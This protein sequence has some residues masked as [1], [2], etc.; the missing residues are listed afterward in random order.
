MRGSQFTPEDTDII[1]SKSAADYQQAS[2]GAEPVQMLGHSMRAVR[3][4]KG[5]TLTYRFTIDQEGDYILTTAMIPT[6]AVD[7]GDIRYRVTVDDTPAVVWSLKEPFRSEE[8]KRNVLRAQALRH[9][10]VHLSRGSHQLI[11]EA[12]DDHIVVDQWILIQST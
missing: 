1:V 2:A 3:L 11:I 8:W 4:P 9:Q 12:L 7:A 10:T 6:H 5:G